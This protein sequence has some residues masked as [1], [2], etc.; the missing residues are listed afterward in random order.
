MSA[1][2]VP[3]TVAALSMSV[4]D[5]DSDV[6]EV[7]ILRDEVVGALEWVSSDKDDAY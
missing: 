4:F 6:K 3:A 1:A 2:A 7:D 5:N